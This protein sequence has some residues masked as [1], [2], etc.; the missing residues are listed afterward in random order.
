MLKFELVSLEGTKFS[1][2]VFEVLLPT[3]DGIIGVF[4]GHSSLVSLAKTGVVTIRRREGDNDLKLEHF[5]INGG[6]IEIADDH[7]RLLVDEADAEDD[8]N[9]AEAQKAFERAQ[10][11][12]RDAKDQ[13]SLDNA[14]GLL[15]RQAVRLKVAELRRHKRR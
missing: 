9:Q 7:V 2:E 1:E 10:Q 13:V 6:V 4:P 14:Q 11:L 15:D 5:A 12:K 8:I 3:P